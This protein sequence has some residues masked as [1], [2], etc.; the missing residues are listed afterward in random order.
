MFDYD[1]LTWALLLGATFLGAA[2]QG[3][4]GFGLAFTI[5]PLL[6]VVEPLAVPTVPLLLALPLLVGVVLT[7]VGSLDV[8][9][10]GLLMLGRLPGTV[11]GGALLLLVQTSLL[12]VLVGV[13]LLVSVAAAVRAAAPTLTTRTQLL[14]GFASG[15]MGTAAGMGGPPLSL[16][17]RGRPASVLRPTISVALLA[18]VGMSM[19][20]VLALGRWDPGHGLLALSLLPPALAGLV[21]SRLVNRRLRA[22]SVLRFVLVLGAVAG[23]AT[24][25]HA[26]LRA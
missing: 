15:V 13:A 14:A 25:L 19:A 4:V 5:V 23:V 1:L 8:R 22:R 21:A 16:A 10:S 3:V 9:G 18:G 2:F 26:L 24:I 7:D 6:A 17:Y 20:A 12:G 11:L